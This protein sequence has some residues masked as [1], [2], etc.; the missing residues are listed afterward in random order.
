MTVDDGPAGGT[1]GID[2][3]SGTSAPGAATDAAGDATGGIAG[4][5]TAGV[6][7]DPGA[8]AAVAQATAEVVR[9]TGPAA[10]SD[11]AQVRA[12]LSDLLGDDVRSR[13]VEVDAVVAAVDA[14]SARDLA[15]GGDPS[16]TARA[17]EGRGLDPA[18]ANNAV[19]VWLHALGPVRAPAPKPQFLNAPGGAFDPARRPTSGAPVTAGA[20]SRPGT[21]GAPGTGS[22]TVP[23]VP[24]VTAVTSGSA[25]AVPGAG[26]IPVT[27]TT[28]GAATSAATA[29]MAAGAGAVGFGVPAYGASAAAHPGGAGATVL[30]WLGRS[31]TLGS[32]TAAGLAGLVG[33]LVHGAFFAPDDS[34]SSSPLA[35]GALAL[36]LSGL[37]AGLIAAWPHIAAR[38]WVKATILLAAGAAVGVALGAGA[39]F[40]ANDYYMARVDRYDDVPQGV[41]V[42]IWVAIAVA[43]G[44]AAGALRSVRGLLSGAIGGIVGG[45]VGGAA[46]WSLTDP[47]AGE[48]TSLLIDGGDA[49]T[50][51]AILL[52]T[53][54]IGG[55]IGA[56][57]RVVR[58]V[59]ITVIE[60]NVKRH[61]NLDRQ[62]TTI[63]SSTHCT[64]VLRDQMV[65]PRHLTVV[66]TS[67]AVTIQPHAPV[68]LLDGT[69]LN[70]PEVPVQPGAFIRVG[71]TTIRFDGGS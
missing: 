52:A 25:A 12:M 38:A 23:V 2:H 13:R 47:Q 33:A 6:S 11:P 44:T 48:D 63:G 65:A 68:T 17:L 15:A 28:S 8:W 61:L 31:S 1:S 29:T 36:L 51:F 49:N 4:E 59:G 56:A 64:I 57:E 66:A 22:P 54:I 20:P 53:V 43:A 34:S 42:A 10:V 40:V 16:A 18:V 58:R 26:T 19:R 14:G 70:A 7:S 21:P 5:S 27:S 30:G 45:A 37:T 24:V 3:G 41:T 39:L 50:L 35:A 55:C 32:A 62:T 69:P 71:T 9:T 67:K 60:G 46:F